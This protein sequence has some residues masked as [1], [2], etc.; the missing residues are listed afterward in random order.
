MIA[1]RLLH[2][3]PRAWLPNARVERIILHWT[4][5]GPY[6]NLIDGLHYHLLVDKDGHVSRGRFPVGRWCPHTRHLN[7]GSVGIA[8][9]GMAK[10]E[11]SP[12]S[13]GPSPLNEAQVAMLCAAAA[14]V[15][16]RYDLVVTERTVLTHCEVPR[17]YGVPQRGRLPGAK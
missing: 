14:E 15:A 5:G 2:R 17:V 10:A 3:V 4:A 12:F 1:D 9:C 6:P 11:P 16:V 13:A 7:T 8:A